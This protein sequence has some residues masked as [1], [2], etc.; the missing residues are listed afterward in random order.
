MKRRAD[1]RFQKKIKLPNGKT[2]T[3]Y[4]AAKSEREAVKDFNR[5]MLTL[6]TEQMNKYLFANIADEWNTEYRKR[7]SDIN[8][9]KNTR[10]AYNRII[11]Y[12]GNYYIEETTAPL[13]NQFLNQLALMRYGKKTVANY[14]SLLNM[15]FRFAIL[16]GY[17]NYNIMQDI[18]LPPNLPQKRRELPSDRELEIVNSHYEEFDFLPYFLLNTGLR[19][20]EALALEIDKD[21]DFENKIITVNKHL[22]HDGNKPIIEQKTKTAASERT[23]ILLDRVAEKIDRRKGL[24]FGN[25]DGMPYTKGQLRCRWKHYQEKYAVTLTAHQLRHGFATM[26]FEAGIDEKDAQELMGHSDITTTRTIYT[27]IRNK[28]REETARKLN[29]FNF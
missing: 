13:I 3:L 1:G 4:S 24:L 8:Y 15:I 7:I 26:L 22:L 5:Q 18:P 12:F 28:R 19:L 16:H 25:D 29:E 10:A 20:S 17:M 23:V 2:K 11:E 9:R 14:H 6:E 21:I 27:H